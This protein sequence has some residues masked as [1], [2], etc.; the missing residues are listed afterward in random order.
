VKLNIAPI[1]SYYTDN[2]KSVDVQGN[3]VFE[4][5][6][7]LIRQFPDL[8]V[9]IDTQSGKPAGFINIFLNK[10]NAATQDMNKPVKDGDELSVEYQPG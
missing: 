6:T 10:E 3:T 2:Q 4:C 5:L 8:G 1:L 7:Y 9:I